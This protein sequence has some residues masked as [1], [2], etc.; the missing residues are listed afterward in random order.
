MAAITLPRA[1][2]RDPLAAMTT[3][4]SRVHKRTWNMDNYILKFHFLHVVMSLKVGLIEIMSIDQC[5]RKSTRQLL[6][7][8]A[9]FLGSVE[10]LTV[11]H[12]GVCTHIWKK[13]PQ[14]SPFAPRPFLQ[15]QILTEPC[16]LFSSPLC[17]SKQMSS[18]SEVTAVLSAFE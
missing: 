13:W 2:C 3:N 4:I 12:Q 18:G 14:F 15:L 7:E 6:S 8:S 16:F 17:R 9:M 10:S 1:S 5:S 11:Q